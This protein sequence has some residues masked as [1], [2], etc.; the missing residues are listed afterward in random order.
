MKKIL[1][2]IFFSLIFSQTVFAD[3]IL[4]D[5]LFYAVSKGDIKQVHTL[6]LAQADPNISNKESGFTALM[7]SCAFSDSTITE[8]LLDAGANVNQ[9][10]TTGKSAL[11]YAVQKNNIELASLLLDYG[12]EANIKTTDGKTPFMVARIN[13]N[14]NM[15]SLLLAAENR[16]LLDE[17]EEIPQETSLVMLDQVK[18]Q[19]AKEEAEAIKD[20]ESAKKHLFYPLSPNFIQNILIDEHILKRTATP[21]VALVTPYSMLRYS[22]TVADR[23]NE[24]ID[25]Y[26]LR[27]TLDKKDIAWLWVKPNKS[28]PYIDSVKIKIGK[29][30][31]PALS[32][33]IYSPQ[34]LFA[35][36]GVDYLEVWSF[37]IKLF[38]KNNDLTQ[39]IISYPDG[40]KHILKI[41][42]EQFDKIPLK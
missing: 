7:A 5:E 21:S 40:K 31:Y 10:T 28:Q 24:E 30:I 1:L 39:I 6:L 37:P 42:A 32:R 36:A 34:K 11:Y 13:K 23:N 29:Q 8:L 33:S 14:R 19:R 20:T 4:D 35:L 17:Y 15:M 38:N 3:K 2:V 9:R 18:I 12:A 41:K 22:F 25:D 26:I 27:Q 16:T